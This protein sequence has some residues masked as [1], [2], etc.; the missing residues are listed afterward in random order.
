[1]C[2]FRGKVEVNDYR[3]VKVENN[4]KPFLILY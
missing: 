2:R 3:Y 4:V 1:M